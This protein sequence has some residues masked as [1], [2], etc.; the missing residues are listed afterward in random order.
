M[1][2]PYPCFARR[3]NL[4]SEKSQSIVA[5][6]RCMG[7]FCDF[8]FGAVARGP[9]DDR[10]ALTRIRFPGMIVRNRFPHLVPKDIFAC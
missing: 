1:L 5:R 7:L 3:V 6:L 8:R 9:L 10:V 2:T 4:N